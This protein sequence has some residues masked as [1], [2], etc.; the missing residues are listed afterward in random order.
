MMPLIRLYPLCAMMVLCVFACSDEPNTV[1]PQPEDA[2]QDISADRSDETVDSPPDASPVDTPED[3]LA[4]QPPVAPSSCAPLEAPS[5]TI[6]RVTPSEANQLAQIVQDAAS[7]TTILLEDG[8]YKMTAS[9]EGSRRLQFRTPGVTLRSASGDAEAVVIDG[10]YIT[11]EMVFIAADD[12]TIADLTLVRAED[13]LVHVTG[14]SEATIYRSRLHNLRLIDSGEQFVKINATSQEGN[15]ADDGSVTCS[16]FILTDEGRPNIERAVNGCYTGGIDTHAGQG[17]VV[18]DN[19]FEGIYCAGEGLA[20]HA[21]HFWRQSRDTV[22]ERNTIINCARGIGF[23]L[24]STSLTRTYPDNPYPAVNDV[25]HYDGVIRNNIIFADIAYYDTG[26]EIQRAHGASVLHNTV[27]STERA[28][29]FF[30][31]ID[32]RFEST[33]AVVSNNIAR[34]LTTRND[35][36]SSG[37]GNVEGL[38]L[39]LFVDVGA[40]DFHLR[41]DAASVIDQG[42][43]AGQVADDVDG[44]ARDD[45]KPD[46]GA[47]ELNQ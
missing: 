39:E 35:P 2:S 45:G 40:R 30:S 28:T 33:K 34:R 29:G 13:H 20:E 19:H 42:D 43:V 6:V 31:S 47:D 44:Q 37:G 26:I 11:K 46:V 21:V 5:G 9:G 27:M 1:T 22:V 24:G 23:G 8:V 32:L 14:G 10:E 15:F 38:N 16:Q 3:L 4:D 7:G 12:V 25:E 18:A 17:W 41:D 36:T